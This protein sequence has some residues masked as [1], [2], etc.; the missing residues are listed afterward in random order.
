[1]NEVFWEK[2][3]QNKKIN[4]LGKPSKEIED[5]TS[6]L[7]KGSSILDMAC[8]DRQC[9]KNPCILNSIIH[10]EKHEECLFEGVCVGSLNTSYQR[11]WEPQVNTCFY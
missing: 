4:T 1:M 7:S 3:Y 5:L 6:K 8:G 9:S 2:S 10:L 11:F